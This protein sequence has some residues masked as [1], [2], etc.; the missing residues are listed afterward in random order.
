MKPSIGR[1][2]HF[3]LPKQEYDRNDLP[4]Q[5]FPAII[6]AVRDAE[7]YQAPDAEPKTEQGS[8]V[9]LQVFGASGTN[10]YTPTNVPFSPT[11]KRGFWSWPPKV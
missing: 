9:D 7:V 4:L 11:P 8:R 5:V 6:T 2:V 1:I 10:S 3:G